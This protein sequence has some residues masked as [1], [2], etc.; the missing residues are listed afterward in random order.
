M[1][2]ATQS[3]S[4]DANTLDDYEEGTWPLTLN[5]FTTTGSLTTLGR[6][7]KIGSVVYIYFRISATTIAWSAGSTI[8]GLPFT[9]LDSGAASLNV[10]AAGSASAGTA[11]IANSQYYMQGAIS[12]L[13][14]VWATAFYFTST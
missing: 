12:G 2:P 3:A 1:F 4:S 5:S 6:Y 11:Q 13:S 9:A 8:T 7:R 14:D 10:S